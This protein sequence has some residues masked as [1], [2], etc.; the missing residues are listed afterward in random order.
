MLFFYLSHFAFCWITP[1]HIFSR[2]KARIL[3]SFYG[4][5]TDELCGTNTLL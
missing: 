2:L 4:F 5:L 1:A 3:C